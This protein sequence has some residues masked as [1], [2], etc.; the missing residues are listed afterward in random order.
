MLSCTNFSIFFVK[1]AAVSRIQ[2]L[3]FYSRT[4][5]LISDSLKTNSIIQLIDSERLKINS[6]THGLILK[7]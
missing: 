7:T 5:L 6:F 1:Y 2:P 3:I 4:N